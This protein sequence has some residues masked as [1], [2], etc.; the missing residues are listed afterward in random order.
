MTV[1]FTFGQLSDEDHGQWLGKLRAP[2]AGFRNQSSNWTATWYESVC[3]LISSPW[4]VT[5][6]IDE[7]SPLF[8]MSLEEMVEENGEIIAEIDGIDEM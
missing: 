3:F 6:A 2:G 5:H 8:N 7:Q 4:T 1:I